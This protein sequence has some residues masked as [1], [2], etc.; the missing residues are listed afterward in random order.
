MNNPGQNFSNLKKH[1][2]KSARIITFFL[3]FV[4]L[5]L[6]Y[7][8]NESA[9]DPEVF[10]ETAPESTFSSLEG[11]EAVLYG[12]HQNLAQV[13][14]NDAAQELSSLAIMTDVGFTTQGAIAN[15]AVNFQ[16]F[17]LDGVGSSLYSLFWNDPYQAIRNA[18]ILLENIDDA[19]VSD[20]DKELIRAE[21]RFIRAVA[22]YKLYKLFGAVPLRTST[23]QE[24]ELPK[25]SEEELISFIETE[26]L[27]VV[28][29]LPA[30]G[31]EKAYGRAHKAA[32]MGYLTK[33]YLNTRQWQKTADMGQQII[34][35]GTFNL[36][37]SYFELFQVSNEGNEEIIWARTGRADLGRS[38][39][40]SIMNFAW[41]AGFLSNP[42]T[43]LEFCDGCRN[44]ATM[45]RLRDDFWD[46]FA[47]ND[48]RTDLIIREYINNDGELINLL[49]PN[50]NVRPFKYWPADDFAGPAYGNDV[51]DIRYADILLSRAEALNELNGPNQ[52][53][54]DLIN[55]VRSRAG[56]DDLALGVFSSAEELRDHI[57]DERGWEFWW[58]GKR[59]DDLIRHGTFIEQAQERGL[60]AQD[61]MVRHPIPQFALDAN[62]NLEQNPGY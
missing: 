19:D 11:I 24:L 31:Q 32:A 50:D 14:G 44:F 29:G 7:G 48:N 59:R 1:I 13:G 57:L 8:C 60:P 27:A 56:L 9:L 26:L 37:P 30:Y 3:A 58:E 12:A 52:E 55:Q 46:S 43:G 15:W 22:Y 38:A 17:I 16:D 10:S 47:S 51:P 34:D 21:S 49:P 45:I 53:S 41:P 54:I 20:A 36:F 25:A 18:H 33:L 62:P 4:M 2:M 40:I 61:H 39:N 42:R 5:T 35:L 6:I 23:D 28:P